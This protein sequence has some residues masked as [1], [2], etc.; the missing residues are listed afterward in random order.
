M[1]FT[2]LLNLIYQNL[3][4]AS[5]TTDFKTDVYRSQEYK[6]VDLYYLLFVNA[7]FTNTLFRKHWISVL[8][9][10]FY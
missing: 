6:S 2:E 1:F 7:E 8:C 9:N 3:D 4:M 10:L 5:S